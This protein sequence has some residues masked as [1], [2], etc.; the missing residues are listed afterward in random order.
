MHVYEGTVQ[1]LAAELPDPSFIQTT[2]RRFTTLFG[3]APTA[4]EVQSWRRSWPR[5]VDALL[6]AGL[7][8]LFVLLE[9]L[10]PATGERVDALLLGQAPDGRLRT[11][12]I[13]L[14][15]WTKV[16]TNVARPGMVKAGERIVQHP[17]RQVGGYVTYLQDWVSK[18]T[19]P[20]DVR[21]IAVLHDAPS[22]LVGTLRS[23]TGQG[24]SSRFPILGREDLTPTPTPGALADRLSCAGV[25]APDNGQLRGFLQARHRPSA[26]LLKRA[27]G[28]IEGND[29]LTLIGDQDLARQ[30]VLHTVTE[31]RS[32][33]RKGIV[34]V[35]GG[36]GTGKTVIACRLLGDLCAQPQANPRLATPSGTLTRQLQRT[37]GSASRGLITTLVD[38]VPAGL[39]SN[40]VVLLDE[41]HRARTYPDH[42]RDPFPTVLGQMIERVGVSVLFLDEQQIVRPSEGVTLQ[43]LRQY[44]RSKG[45]TFRHINLTTQFRCNGS[46]AYLDWVNQLL[47]P[48]GPAPAWT[49]TDYDLDAAEN[50]HD[51]ENWVTGHITT[52]RSARIT[53]GFCWPWDS[54]P[55]P[56]LRP[57]VDISWTG[58]DGPITWSRPWNAR[59]DETSMDV[60]DVPG[61]PYW[62][63]DTG[64]HQ[65]VGC[66]YTAQGMEYD[67]NVVILGRDIVR[68]GNRWIADPSA[69]HDKPLKG[70]PAHRYLIYALNAYR[71]LASRGSKGTRLYST[72]PGTQ[73]YLQSLMP[74]GTSNQAG[75]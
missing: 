75:G 3:A 52:G 72:D 73:L 64:G 8:E 19:S 1:T 33:A 20:I 68:R 18:D 66:I 50:P 7:G 25:S 37:V 60:P 24:P 67:Y 43:E 69:S 41:A 57:E 45:H 10:L 13:E 15:Q 34:V 71:V 32:Q 31:A 29:A 26:S 39:Q 65:Q 16:H 5:L 17:A 23:L 27:G 49:G 74:G 6:A 21:G 4:Q 9:Y 59:S 11:V 28:M 46:R 55:T 61:R 62:A 53:A 63:T 12:V 70:L 38:R 22:A 42:R 36:P 35:T 54:P 44:A 2:E 56:P 47:Q 14:K 48:A 51:F 40:S 58:P 30:E